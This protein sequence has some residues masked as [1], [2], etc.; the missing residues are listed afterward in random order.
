MTQTVEISEAYR[1][2]T[3]H[4]LGLW[5]IHEWRLKA[6]T[7]SPAGVEPA[8]ELMEGAKALAKDRIAGSARSGETY[9]VGYVGVHAGKAGN[10][11]FIDWWANENEVYHHVYASPAARPTDFQYL[12]PTGA[13]ACVW[14]LQLIWFEREA[15]VASILSRPEAP[16][17]DAYLTTTM[18]VD[19]N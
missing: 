11:V 3:I 2:R 6:Y 5:E 10:F 17:I 15:W 19:A 7:I 12:T 16:D 13:S 9:R 8:Q 18:Q 4:F 14:D 1:P